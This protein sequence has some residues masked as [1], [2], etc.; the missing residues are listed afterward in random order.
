MVY[1]WVMAIYITQ[2][3]TSLATTPMAH[4]AKKSIEASP[5]VGSG[6]LND[7]GIHIPLTGN[8][9]AIWSYLE[10]PSGKHTKS[11]WKWPLK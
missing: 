2:L 8:P 6:E 1:N 7:L 4:P 3:L 9:L 11:Y 10:I 5:V